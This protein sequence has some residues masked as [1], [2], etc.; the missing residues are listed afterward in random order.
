[1]SIE[2]KILDFIQ[3]LHTL[4]LDKIMVGVTKLGDVGIIWIILTAILLIIPKTR[5]TG[6]VMLVALVVQTVLCNVILKNLFARTRPYDVNTTVQLLVPKL[7]D[8]S[9]PSGHTS[10]SFTA[11]SALYFSKDKLWKPALILA[12]LIAVSRLYLYV[13]YPTDVLGGLLLG[14]L[15]GY[16]GYKIMEKVKNKGIPG[17]S[18][19]K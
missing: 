15:S 7:H 4:V 16:I 11:V 14:V 3:T 13:H 2:F 17:I 9:F 18:Q 6:G 5:R 19:R 12:C 10:A 1:M 8:F